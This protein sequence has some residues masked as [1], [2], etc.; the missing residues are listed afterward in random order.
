MSDAGSLFDETG[1]EES[2]SKNCD[3]NSVAATRENPNISGL[4]IH[5]DLQISEELATNLLSELDEGNY[6]RG[7]TNQV[8]LFGRRK[9]SDNGQIQSGLPAFLNDLIRELSIICRPYIDTRVWQMLFPNEKTEPRSRQVILNRYQPGEGISP[10]V[11]LLDRYDDGIIGVSLGSGCA[12]DFAAIESPDEVS[13]QKSIWLCERSII[14]LEGDA[15]YN[16]THGIRPLHGDRVSERSV[17]DP[18]WI[19]RRTRT[20]ITIRW[21]LPGAEI[22]GQ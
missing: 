9:I 1:T 2:E 20:S 14:V 15:R 7:A 21:L 11:D 13:R 5:P 16:W 4:H 18:I 10:H 3:L 12:M 8:M 22:V 6:F 17:D 19:P